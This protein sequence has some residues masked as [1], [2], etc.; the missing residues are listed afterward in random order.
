MRQDAVQ[1]EM[2]RSGIWQLSETQEKTA[3]TESR[4]HWCLKF[5][6]DRGNAF[7][8]LC[9]FFRT[10]SWPVYAR[11][12]PPADKTQITLPRV[13]A[14]TPNKY[15]ESTPNPNRVESSMTSCDAVVVLYS[16]SRR[17]C[18]PMRAVIQLL[19]KFLINENHFVTYT[20]YFEIKI[21]HN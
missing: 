10:R 3:G 11:V 13:A 14:N 16:R 21:L 9:K 18:N 20:T 8:L 19:N 17:L 7:F 4:T 6:A 15:I 1:L 2:S 5:N 12:I